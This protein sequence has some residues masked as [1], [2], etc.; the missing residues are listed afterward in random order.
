MEVFTQTKSALQTI[1]EQSWVGNVS[2]LLPPPSAYLFMHQQSDLKRV[3]DCLPLMSNTFPQSCLHVWSQ[4]HFI[5]LSVSSLR[6]L[7]E[8]A[9]DCFH[10]CSSLDPG[11]IWMQEAFYTSNSVLSTK[12]YEQIYIFIVVTCIKH[13]KAVII[14]IYLFFNFRSPLYFNTECS[15]FF[16]VECH[17]SLIGWTRV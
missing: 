13:V 1:L 5:Q 4:L 7:Y 3:K 9:P 6:N 11:L 15:F 14:C 2:V 12:I 8:N 16:G 17:M 10:G